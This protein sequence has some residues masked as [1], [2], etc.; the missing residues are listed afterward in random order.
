MRNECEGLEVSRKEV[1]DSNERRRQEKS[2]ESEKEET[3]MLKTA[4]GE[5][6]AGPHSV[7]PRTG[8]YLGDTSRH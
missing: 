6:Q 2:K 7:W 5:P 3:V 1:K 8:G 4:S